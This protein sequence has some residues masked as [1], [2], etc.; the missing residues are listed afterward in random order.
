MTLV[1]VEIKQLPAL[2]FVLCH[3]SHEQ[4]TFVKM[5]IANILLR[6]LLLLLHPE[7]LKSLFTFLLGSVAWS[8][9]AKLSSKVLIAAA[10]GVV[11]GILS[12]NALLHGPYKTWYE[13]V[14]EKA[15]QN[16]LIG[17]TQPEVDLEAEPLNFPP[18]P[19]MFDIE[20]NPWDLP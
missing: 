4:A 17:A 7:V 20:Y 6:Y 1:T 8:M 9:V 16:H 19:D 2:S 3:T 5:S 10:A 18:M 12:I 14:R 15:N 13:T 11:F